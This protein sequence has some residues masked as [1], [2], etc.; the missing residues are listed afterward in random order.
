MDVFEG[1]VMEVSDII[2]K[3]YVD[4]NPLSSTQPSWWQREF[5]SSAEI[6]DYLGCDILIIPTWDLE[7]TMSTLTVYGDEEGNFEKLCVEWRW[8]NCSGAVK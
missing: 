4:H 5:D 2:L 6:R 8:I 1:Q 3:Q 7:E